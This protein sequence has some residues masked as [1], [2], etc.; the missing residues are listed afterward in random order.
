[1]ATKIT[2]R[3]KAGKFALF[4]LQDALRGIKEASKMAA[5]VFCGLLIFFGFSTLF[6]FIHTSITGQ[7]FLEDGGIA[8]GISWSLALF[9][10]TCFL[11]MVLLGISSAA[12]YISDK[13]RYARY[14]IEEE[15]EESGHEPVELD[16]YGNP[17]LISREKEQ[18]MHDLAYGWKPYG[19]KPS[20]D[21]GGK[22][23]GPPKI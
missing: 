12:E 21:K 14:E 7:S 11:I 10:L 5:C 22:G 16:E 2:K 8:Y 15:L 1:M 13:W 9:V 23:D 4:I 19:R 18:E 6:G 3:R 17:R 20:E